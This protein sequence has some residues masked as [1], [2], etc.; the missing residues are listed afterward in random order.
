MIFLHLYDL[1]STQFPFVSGQVLDSYLHDFST[2][3]SNCLDELVT[4]KVA[5]GI[6]LCNYFYYCTEN[7]H[8]IDPQWLIIHLTYLVST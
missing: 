3:E 7:K 1:I 6:T 2:K 4:K 8:A 5:A